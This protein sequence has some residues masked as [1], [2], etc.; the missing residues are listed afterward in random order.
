MKDTNQS[1]F[2]KKFRFAS[3]EDANHFLI[4]KILDLHLM[5][6]QISFL[7]FKKFRFASNE[8]ANTFFDW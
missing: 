8:E 6:M 2:W 4:L 3:N 5:K 7:L 1:L